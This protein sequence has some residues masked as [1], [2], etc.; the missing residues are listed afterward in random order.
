MSCKLQKIKVDLLFMK[1]NN[2]V[3]TIIAALVMVGCASF[4]PEYKDKDAQKAIIYPD[5]KELE[6]RFFLLGDAGY[7]QA[8]GTSL[9]ILAFKSMLDSMQSK[10]STTIFLGDNIYPAGMP[11]KGDPL[12]TQSEYRIDAQLD[13]LEN[14]DGNIIFIPDWWKFI[15]IR[16]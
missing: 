12:R 16:K 9:G 8:G 13:A 5:Q 7:S 6:H 3:L 1:K 4:E 11:P 2:I 14:Y 15:L 10:N